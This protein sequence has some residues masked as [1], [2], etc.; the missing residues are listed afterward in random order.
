MTTVEL[1][2]LRMSERGAWHRCPQR[3]QYAYR[4][5]L[6]PK[7]KQADAR[8]FGIGVHEALAGWYQPGRKRGPNPADTFE[9]WAGDEVAYVKTYL[10]DEYDEAV[11]VDAVELGVGMLTE[12]VNH[13]GRDDQWEVI[14]IESPFKVRLHYKNKP[15]AIFA[16]RWDGVIRDRRTRKVLLLEN[17][18]ASQIHT[19]YLVGDDQAMSYLAVANQVLAARGVLKPGQKIAGIQYN[20]LRKALPDDRPEDEQGHKLNKDGEVSKRQ[21]PPLFVRP[22][23]ILRSPAEMR[24]QLERMAEEVS[25]MD[26]ARSGAIP[27]TKSRTR[28]CP[29]CDYWD[30]CLL[31]DRGDNSWKEIMRASYT[32]KDPYADIREGNPIKSAAE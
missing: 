9:Q 29:Y 19:A 7:G 30:M 11:W 8:W 18:T 23:P 32:V 24:R 25:I 22:D 16:S 31:S 3:W 21:P 15:V 4:F 12:Y 5:G 1:P 6:V 26:L 28:D 14:A 13:Y 2:I 17:K 10:G 20:F 27:I